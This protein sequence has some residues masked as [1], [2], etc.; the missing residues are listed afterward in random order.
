MSQECLTPDGQPGSPEWAARARRLINAALPL[1]VAAI[2]DQTPT[3]RAVVDACAG[4]V[5]RWATK[6][7]A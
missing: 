6:R 1:I 3:E 4:H 7:A 5:L 2:P